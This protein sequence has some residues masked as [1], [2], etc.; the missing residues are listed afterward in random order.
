MEIMT[1]KVDDD[2]CG[3]LRLD[4]P[5]DATDAEIGYIKTLVERVGPAFLLHDQHG[6]E[7]KTAGA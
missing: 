5:A 6:D 4:L 2:G 7:N 3:Q 1:L